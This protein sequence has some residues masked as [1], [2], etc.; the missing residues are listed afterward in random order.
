MTRKIRFKITLLKIFKFNKLF[1]CVNLAFISVLNYSSQNFRRQKSSFA[2]VFDRRI[3]SEI[4]AWTDFSVKHRVVLVATIPRHFQ[5][6]EV[7]NEQ[8]FDFQT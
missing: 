4:E 2:Q 5:L 8:E 6:G 1:L 7:A 3:Q